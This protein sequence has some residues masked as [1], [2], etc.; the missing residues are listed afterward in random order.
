MARYCEICHLLSIA[1]YAIIEAVRLCRL[2]R[3]P[4]HITFPPPFPKR[5][6]SMSAARPPRFQRPHTAAALKQPIL[7]VPGDGFPAGWV[8]PAQ[9][10]G[11]APGGAGHQAFPPRGDSTFPS[12]SC[13]QTG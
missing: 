4:R 6:D 8:R 7:D 13:E 11:V 2:C 3:L 5:E 9:T 1:N 12:R 10:Q